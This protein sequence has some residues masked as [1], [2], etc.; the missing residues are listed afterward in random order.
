MLAS[1]PAPTSHGIEIGPLEFRF[2]GLAIALGMIA[3]LFVIR[4]RYARFG[5]DPETIEKIFLWIILIGFLGAR[6]AYVSTH[7]GRFT[8]DPWKVIAVWE[9]GLAFFGGLTFGTATAIFLIRRHGG[10]VTALADSIAIGLPLAQAIGRWGNYF[11]QELFGTPSSLP[12]AVEI[13]PINR[14][15]AHLD[16]ATFHPT[17]LYEML[18]NLATIG[19]LLFTEK[20]F[21]FAPG[22]LFFAYLSSYGVGRFWIELLRTDTTFRFLGISRNGWVA[23]AL[24]LVSLTIFILPQRSPSL[25]P[26]P[27]PATK[28]LSQRKKSSSSRSP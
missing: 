6:L 26:S 28:P 2:Y 24:T 23:F 20:R 12:W 8:D 17:F 9:G 11:N 5:G 16:A 13:D 10:E 1:I 21:R 19:V 7:T 25:S 4:K 27:T 15:Q 14:P 3:A 18:W 22:N